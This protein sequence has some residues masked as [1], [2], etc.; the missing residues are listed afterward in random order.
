MNLFHDTEIAFIS[1]ND[2][3]LRKTYWLFKT[4]ASKRF[5]KIGEMLT[6]FAM[7]IHFPIRWAVKPTIYAHFVGGENLEDCLPTVKN[8]EKFHVGAILDYSVEG[9][10]T[11]QDIAKALDETIKS[12]HNAGKYENIPFA[13]FK[14][15]AFCSV[16]VLEKVNKG[17][18]L[19]ENENKE[20]NEFKAHVKQLCQT[21]YN[22][23][24]PILIDA[25]DSFY[26]NFIDDTVEEMMNLFNKEKAIVYN[27]WQ[28]YRADRLDFLKLSYEKAKAGNYYLGAKFVRGAYM[29]KERERALKMNYTSPICVDKDATDKAYND[30]L[31]FSV[32]HLD[33]IYI[34]NGTHNED[35]VL[36]LCQLMQE[37]NIAANDR[38]ICFSQLYGMSDHISFNL[39][40]VGYNV[41]KYVPYGPVKHV[42]PYLFRRAQEN[43]S[44]GKQAGRE[45]RLLSQEMQRRKALKTK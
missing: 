42:L 39:A 23:N 11:S 13:V 12:I 14:P 19:S 15:T 24:V 33:T 6:K 8:L 34:F 31:R 37:R 45:L 41:A 5:T 28:M 22:A 25:E 20:A 30:A 40:K 32:E 44:A 35:S 4:M 10:H 18:Q 38:R 2:A 7:Y 27:T 9:G 29:E 36:L 1:K 16:E 43:T 3:E 17:T 26:Q 21:A